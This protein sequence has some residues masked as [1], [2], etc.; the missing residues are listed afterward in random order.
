MH[1]KILKYNLKFV[2]S[3]LITKK[4]LFKKREKYEKKK[5]TYTY[6]I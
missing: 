1:F 6:L 2:F 3:N 4:V 5:N